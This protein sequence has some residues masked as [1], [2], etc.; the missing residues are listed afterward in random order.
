M[1]ARLQHVSIPRPPGSAGATREFYG[2]LLEMDEIPPPNSLQDDQVIWF[3]A[4]DDA[5]LH[6]FLEAP[7]DDRSNR[8]LCLV[9]DDL[10]RLRER[11]LA[12]GYHPY[13]VTPIPG[14]PRFFCRDPFGNILEFTAIE[15]DYLQ[16]QAGSA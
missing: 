10:A 3:R 9:V 1:N 12:A 8:H 4:G 15:G 16:L 2:G 5:E 13:A 6:V 14:R 7:L 11:L